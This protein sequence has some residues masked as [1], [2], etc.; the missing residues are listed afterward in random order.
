MLP[1]NLLTLA[2]KLRGKE[3]VFNVT[4]ENARSIIKKLTR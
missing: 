4:F 3:F 2:I 1:T